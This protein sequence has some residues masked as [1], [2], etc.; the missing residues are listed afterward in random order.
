MSTEPC[1]VAKYGEITAKVYK[2]KEEMGFAAAIE[3]AKACNE[4][5]KQKGKVVLCFSAAASQLD[6]IEGL[7]HV[8]IDWSKVIAFHLDEYLGLPA[9]HPA[10][11]KS[12]LK[13]KVEIPFRPGK[14]HYINGSAPDIDEECERYK[15]L[16]K[17]NPID[18]GF[19]GIGENGHIAFND[20][21][22]ADFNDPKL[23][24]VVELDEVCRNQQLN[25]N[26]KSMDEVPVSAISLTIPTIMAF[27]KII[28][29]VPEKRKAKAVKAALQGPISPTCP[30]SILRTHHDATLFCDVDAISELE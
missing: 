10:N 3:A 4:V 23:I 19:V 6:F 15:S 16:I 14:M 21:H 12:W 2:T 22:V 20:P 7:H 29:I 30:A 25:E 9:D 26:F 11:F 27:K 28:S 8:D 24:K 1:K 17:E 5:I 18:I 13:D